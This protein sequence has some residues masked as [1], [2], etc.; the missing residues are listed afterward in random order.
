[1]KISEYILSHAQY[2]VTDYLYLTRKGWTNK[3]I[4]ARW[5]EELGNQINPVVHQPIFDLVG[6]LN[7]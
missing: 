7:S 2:T 5:D 3:E 1:M 6:Y 4:E